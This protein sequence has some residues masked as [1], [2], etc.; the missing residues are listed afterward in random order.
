MAHSS[1]F[2]ANTKLFVFVCA[3]ICSCT[4]SIYLYVPLS[5]S[6]NESSFMR[7]T[8]HYTVFLCEDSS[9]DELSQ[10]DDFIP[11]FPDQFLLSTPFEWFIVSFV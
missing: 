5:L 10:D 2:T 6:L 3:Y 9:G 7:P 11:A 8:R 4:L 1:V